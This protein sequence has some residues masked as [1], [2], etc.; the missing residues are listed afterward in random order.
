MTEPQKGAR[1]GHAEVQRVV[2]LTIDN[3]EEIGITEKD[4]QLYLPAT[5]RRR[6]VSGKLREEPVFLRMVSNQHRIKARTQSRAWALE[7][8]LDLDRDRDLIGDLE[9]YCLLAFAICDKDKVQHFLD[10]KQ[11]W[12]AYDTQALGDLWGAYDAWVRM[13]HPSF[14]TWDAEALWRVIAKVRAGRTI[15][16]LAAMPGIEQASC[17]LF[18][19]LE[20]CNSPNAP[21]WLALSGIST[22]ARSVAKN[23]E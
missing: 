6:D 4:G 18:M 12:Q 22:R 3:W 20:A 5:I 2:Q 21:S 17:L 13:L 1:I 15:A 19:A 7:S 9:N 23:S 16:P 11:L 10:A 14:G 8:G